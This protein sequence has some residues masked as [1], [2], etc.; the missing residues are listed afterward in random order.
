[1]SNGAVSFSEG[2]A[3]GYRGYQANKLRMLFP[4]G[5]GL[6]YTHFSLSD[7][8]AKRRGSQYDVTLK[9][10]NAG[11]RR[12]TEVIEGY[13]TY[14]PQAAEPPRALKVFGSI[15]LAPGK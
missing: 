5:Y 2:L 3:I 14:P 15:N 9:V 6:S 11:H 10:K 1:G 13:L 4:F 12:G 8:V 7:L